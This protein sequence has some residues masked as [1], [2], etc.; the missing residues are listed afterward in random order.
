MR[1]IGLIGG[2][3]SGKSTVAAELGALGAKV[4][5]ADV[6]AHQAL[7][8]AEVRAALV[9]RWGT[10]ILTPEGTVSR[11]AVGRLVFSVTEQGRKDLDFLEN[12]LHPRIRRDFEAAIVRFAEAGEKAVVIDAP[13]LL[14]AGWET[15]C[16]IVLFVE[17]RPENRQN[18]ASTQRNWSSDDFSAR[19][20]AQLPI[21]EKRS[22]ATHIVQNTGSLAELRKQVR[23]FWTAEIGV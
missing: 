17:S 5:D 1:V 2:I 20:R 13:L 10:G 19:E 12:L 18:R 16:D 14:E 4:L 3:A 11:P 8:S 7:N 6:A 23:R 22:H 9:E 21:E 15:L